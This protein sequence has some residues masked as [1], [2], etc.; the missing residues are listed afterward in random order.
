MSARIGITSVLHT[1]GSTLTH[2]PHMLE[3]LGS[4]RVEQEHH[5]VGRAKLW[6]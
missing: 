4:D 6:P 5:Q 3:V 2:H 1:W